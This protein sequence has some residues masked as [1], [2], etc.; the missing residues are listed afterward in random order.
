MSITFA[1][2]KD[3][4][5]NMGWAINTEMSPDYELS[6]SDTL[7]KLR[8]RSRQLIKD[9]LVVAGIQQAIIN[10][11]GTPTIKFES[12][13]RI[14]AEQANKVWSDVSSGLDMTK[15]IS[16]QQLVEQIVSWSFAD[17]DIG[18]N[19]TID[20]KR[21]SI[22]TVVD[23]VEAQRIKTPSDKVKDTLIQHGV[24]YDT[25]GRIDG[26]YV[27]KSEAVDKYS[28]VSSEFNFY[29]AEKISGDTSRI[30]FRMFKAPL[31][32]RPKATRMY[33]VITPCLTFLKHLS[34]YQEAVVVGAR[35]AACFAGF[36]KSTNPAGAFKGL[37][38]D[39]AT[40]D[41]VDDP[42][43]S[44]KRVAKL[45]PGKIFFLRPNE[46]ITF[47]SPN[48]P[49]DNVDPYILRQY[50]TLSHYIRIAYP[51]LF[52][53]VSEVNYSALRGAN[54]DTNRV[55]DRW[56]RDADLIIN[57]IVNTVMYEASI[58]GLLR[59][60][61]EALKVKIRW[62]ASTV[63][64]EEKEARADKVRLA[65]QT[66]SKQMICDERSTS[67]DDVLEERKKEALDEVDLE[68]AI[69]IKKK[70]IEEANGI[71]FPVEGAQNRNA[72]LREGEQR[73]EKTGE[74]TPEDKKERRKDDGNW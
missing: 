70:E 71:V 31:N 2:A 22:K 12:T 57:W 50:K 4:A 68:A 46:D 10:L 17:G 56:R 60:S 33:P 66:V 54:Q 6:S 63:L 62:P 27:K 49:G 13:S 30:V 42:Q 39:A 21:T 9:D 29:P 20:K 47:A 5:Y 37:T 65:N 11:V 52:M 14:Q 73:D 3:T 41:T 16:F 74:A 43:D 36:V 28:D 67:Y 58:R 32:P 8:L 45:Q 26:Y 23:L 55:R 38:T 59:G 19:L 61:L 15:L 35:V 69:L 44:Y 51:I 18:I 24:K 1:G 72:E 34:D 7:K 48:R 25:D 64:D 53:D 40:G